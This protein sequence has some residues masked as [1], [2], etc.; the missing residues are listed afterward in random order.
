M[1]GP[2]SSLASTVTL[3]V[4]VDCAGRPPARKRKVTGAVEFAA[5]PQPEPRSGTAIGR[6]V[7]I[8]V[9]GLEGAIEVTRTFVREVPPVLTT[10]NVSRAVS[11]LSTKGSPSP[12]SITGS[13]PVSSMAAPGSVEESGE[14]GVTEAQSLI[15]PAQESIATLPAP[16]TATT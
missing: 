7:E 16:P 14:R 15:G 2:G 9:S 10:L 12:V 11:Q 3:N 5:P 1:T 8:R 6:D 13:A 4:R